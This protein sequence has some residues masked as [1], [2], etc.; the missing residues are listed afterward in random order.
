M[1]HLDETARC[2]HLERYEGDRWSA[3]LPVRSIVSDAARLGSA[4]IVLAHNHPSGDPSPSQAD[5][6]ATRALASAGEALDLIVVDH[7]IYARGDDC[8][9]MRRLGY[10]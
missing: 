9:S 4:G 10:L 8:R 7:L 5:C 2:I 3:D 6:R 1:A